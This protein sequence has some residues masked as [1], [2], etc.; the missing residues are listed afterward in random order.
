MKITIL[1]PT[2]DDS[3]FFEPREGVSIAYTGVGLVAS[4]YNTTIEILKNNPDILI[5]AGIAGVYPHSSMKIG[6]TVLV[7]KE[8]CADIGFFFPNGFKHLSDMDLDME[9]EDLFDIECP[10]IEEKMPFESAASLSMNAAMAP[11]IRETD[12]EMENMEGFGFFYACRK[13]NKKFYELRSISN[14]VD[15]NSND[16]WDYDSSIRNLT[17]AL[18]KL[19]DYLRT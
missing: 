11:F 16:Q 17:E 12:G 7:S 1:F 4:T 14:V 3:K 8:K 5:M 13:A 19:I 15:I 2:K 10:Y 9:F 6:D 18:N